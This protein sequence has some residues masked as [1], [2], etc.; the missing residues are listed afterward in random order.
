[1]LP[2][3]KVVLYKHGVGYF[4][5]RGRVEGDAALDLHFRASEMNDVLKSLT[6]L[7]LTR[8]HI[9]SISYESTTPMERQLEDIA[10]RLPDDNAV[11]GLL[12][13]IKGARVAVQVAGERVEGLVMGIE[14]VERRVD[15]AVVQGHHL[16]L[17]VGGTALRSFDLQDVAQLDFLD[18]ELQQDLQHL[19]QVLIA[20]KRKD[21]KRLTVFAQGEGEREILASYIVETPVWKTS[22]RVLL[23]DEQPLIQG[24]ALVDNPQDEDWV[25]VELSLVAG[26]PISFVHDLYS[27]RYKR[28]PVVEVDEEEAYAPPM[29]EDAVFA[30]SE[31]LA[32]EQGD[33]GP[34]RTRSL[35]RKAAAPRAAGGV[36]GFAA[37]VRQDEKRAQARDRSVQVQT[38][39]VE[40]G[41]LFEY[42][43]ENPVTVK[44]SQSALVP[45]LQGPFEGDRV[46]VYNTAVREKNPLSAILFKNTTGMT[47]EGGPLTVLEDEAY[48]GES[49]LET[50]K[51]KEERLVPYSVELGCVVSIDHQSRREDVRKVKIVDGVL[52]AWR[53][54]I[55]ETAY[56]IRN[57]KDS[58]VDLVLE[59]PFVHAW[60]L[61]DTPK[62]YET[63]DNFYRFRLDVP[64]GKTVRYVVQE[65]GDEERHH[66]L[67]NLD[68]ETLGLWVSR[69][70][71]DEETE[72]VLRALIGMNQVMGR[73]GAKIQDNEKRIAALFEDQ[74]RQREN[75]KALG[76]S[77]QERG[78]RERYVK[79][80]TTAE[81]RLAL[82]RAEIERWT[83]ERRKVE[84]ELKERLHGVTYEATL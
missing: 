67:S 11:S 75:L 25:D 82:L 34:A 57:K 14:T 10:I 43:I 13:E 22:Y 81:E 68:T 36:A 78:L 26:L 39:T 4:E 32:M 23:G 24:W 28:R 66:A 3:R 2:I 63:T 5:R 45:I 58:P 35:R 84:K 54:R 29:L 49:M 19:L 44:R 42:A 48:V 83:A 21:L 18:E 77:Q 47:L 27:P 50:M 53:Y 17:L 59:H 51:P 9:A 79:E 65:K 8:G 30:A 74:E 46:A 33:A 76:D 72:G 16:A 40:V 52:H 56:V 6:T 73:L 69:Q 41:D 61:V 1:M 62:P 38:R 31:A 70:Y 55:R 60:E 7:D 64:A 80:L 20:A 37:D 12:A 71:V 15:D